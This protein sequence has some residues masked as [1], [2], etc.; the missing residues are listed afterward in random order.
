M[1]KMCLL[2]FVQEMLIL[3]QNYKISFQAYFFKI[4]SHLNFKILVSC[5]QV[6]C[7]GT[8]KQLD[9]YI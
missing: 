1:V 2:E 8:H 5:M 6:V 3:I 4:F 7:E 9:L